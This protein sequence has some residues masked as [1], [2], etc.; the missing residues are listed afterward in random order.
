MAAIL[1]LGGKPVRLV[2]WL[3]IAFGFLGLFPTILNSTGSGHPVE[4]QILTTSSP[5]P[6][7]KQVAAYTVQPSYPKF[8]SIPKIGLGN[9]LVRSF[10][11]EKNG[12][13]GTP[14]SIY[15][16]GWYNSSSKPGQAGAVF[17]YGHVASWTKYSVFQNLNKLKQGDEISIT[18]GDNTVFH[19]EVTGSKTYAYNAVD[20]SRVLSP[21]SPNVSGLNLMTCAG[22]II[23]VG[24]AKEYSQRLVVFTKQL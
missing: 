13:I 24:G 15:E 12:T 17:I 22:K 7:A 5:P 4:G 23:T 20:M 9:I 16:A 6:T 1:K 8:I 18:R 21:T 3:L 11:L 2:G 14:N 10:G 19:Y